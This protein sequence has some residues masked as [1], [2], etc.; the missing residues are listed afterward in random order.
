M[1]F[2]SPTLNRVI[3]LQVITND[4]IQEAADLILEY[5]NTNKRYYQGVENIIYFDG[6]HGV[7]A[8]AVLATIAESVRSVRSKFDIIIHVDCSL[9][10]S[11]RGLQRRIAE[12][13]KLDPMA[14]AV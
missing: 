13:I 8:S 11:R 2:V 7:G 14:M 5:C 9:W 4:S 6:W 12:E 10:E 3:L 1:E